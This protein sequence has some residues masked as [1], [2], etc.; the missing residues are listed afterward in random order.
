[1]EAAIESAEREKA[2]LEAALARPESYTQPGRMQELASA[3]EAATAKVARLY[4]RWEAL[5]ALANAR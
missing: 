4:E 5:E 1:M 3:L 2:E